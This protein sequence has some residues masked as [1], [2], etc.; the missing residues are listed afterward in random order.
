MIEKSILEDKKMISSAVIETERLYLRNLLTSDRE[1]LAK[2]LCDAEAMKFYPAPFTEKQVEQWIQ[3]NLDNYRQYGH[4]LWAVI[5]KHNHLFIGDCGITMQEIE[6][7]LFPE[8]GYHI[9]KKYCGNGYATEAAKACIQFAFNNFN[10]NKLIIYTKFDNLPSIKVA[11][12]CNMK[13]EKFFD[14][15]VMGQTVKEVLF[16][17][18]R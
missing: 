4:G 7:E 10:Y 8:V 14:K 11:E 2:V 12:K 15:Q 17:I 6:G 13:F 16:S 5:L 3:W 18:N 1:D 9:L